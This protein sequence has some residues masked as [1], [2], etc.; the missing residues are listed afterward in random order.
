MRRIFR[1]ML[2]SIFNI[3]R[4][5]WRDDARETKT[6]MSLMKMLQYYRMEGRV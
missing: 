3:D 1:E 4:V 6:I 5:F 2:Q